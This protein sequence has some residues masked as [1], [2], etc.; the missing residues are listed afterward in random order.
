MEKVWT[1]KRAFTIVELL[2][3][4][5][6]IA[7]LAAML[8]PALQRARESAMRTNCLNNLKQLGQGLQMYMNDHN[9]SLPPAHNMGDWRADFTYNGGW[10][11]EEK[12]SLG[13]LYGQYLDNREIFLCPSE[14]GDRETTEWQNYFDETAPSGS[15]PDDTGLIDMGNIDDVSYVYSGGATLT[16]D[17]KS[18]GAEL[19]IA[20]D[21]EEEG[22]EQ[23]TDNGYRAQESDIADVANGSPLDTSLWEPSNL[24]MLHN[25][26]YRYVGGLEALDNHGQDGVN[27]LYMDWHAEFD[28]RSWPSPIGVPDMEAKTISNG[29]AADGRTWWVMSDFV[30]RVDGNGNYLETP[31]FEPQ[32]SWDESDWQNLDRIMQYGAADDIN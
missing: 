24:A 19:R 8:L 16:R 18:R 17:E 13:D 25:G 22:D 26:V 32:R 4:M 11:P 30:D 27:V 14:A 12:D 23:P 5:G 29:P 3:V 1:E 6:I 9:Q 10:V 31:P 20:A 2:V 15:P 21:N 7:I 28:A